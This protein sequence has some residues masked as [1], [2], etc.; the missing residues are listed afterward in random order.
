MSDKAGS[1]LAGETVCESGTQYSAIGPP[2]RL[3]GGN[4]CGFSGLSLRPC[5]S[6][7]GRVRIKVEVELLSE[8]VIL[9]FLYSVRAGGRLIK[10]VI[11][12]VFFREQAISSRRGLAGIQSSRYF[13]LG[14][15]DGKPVGDFTGASV[16]IRDEV[17]GCA[18]SD[19]VR[20]VG[21]FSRHLRICLS[22]CRLS[23]VTEFL[24]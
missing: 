6:N 2:Q 15:F 9:G 12:A 7:H 20:L 11:L 10:D 23:S 14:F 24:L 18:S 16:G 3:N 8:Q 17:G 21:G 22:A 13:S 1:L 19:G 5:L 4:G